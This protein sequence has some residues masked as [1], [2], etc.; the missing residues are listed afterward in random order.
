MT[1]DLDQLST[2]LLGFIWPFARIGAMLSISP[3]FG[4]RTL[5]MRVRLMLALALTWAVFPLV[6]QVPSVDPLSLAGVL[7][8]VNQLLI[9]TAM[10]LA[11]Q[12][13]FAALLVAG[14]V[15]G[16]SMGLG[17]A[18]VVDPQNGI[19]VPVIGQL[20]F[21]L[22][23][24]VFL[25]IDGHLA[26]I[27]VLAQSFVTLPLGAQGP[28]PVL[29]RDLAVWSGLMF[30]EGTRLAL[31]VVS[32]ILLANLSL[33]VA[34]R[35]APQLNVFALGFSITLLLGFVTMVYALP[36]LGPLFQALLGRALEIARLAAVP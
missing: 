3:L 26:L 19:Q 11:L 13:A 17:F 5:P 35:A 33:G 25:A 10:G 1:F 18:S 9:G 28:A 36:N 14:Q 34:T 23:A 15:I 21:L 7:I 6:G 24:L 30:S 2:W 31:P 4:A 12:V 20:Y 16:A 29:L 32:V 8:M 27:Q 22:G